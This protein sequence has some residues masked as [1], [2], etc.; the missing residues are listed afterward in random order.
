MA[1]V[2]LETSLEGL[3][4]FKKGKVRDTYDLGDKLLMISTDRIS[5]YDC[6]LPNGIPDKG[7]VLTACSLYWFDRTK[8]IIENHVITADVGEY[9]E[10]AMKYSNLLEGRSMLVK[11]TEPVL[12]E[13]VARG[14]LT[15]S[16]WR[17]YKE[18][19]SVCGIELPPGLTE[20]DKLPEPIF[21]PATKAESGHD[22]NVT[23]EQAVEIVGR[24][25]FDKLKNYTLRIYTQ[26]AR[27]AEKRG[28]IIADTKFEFGVTKEG[29][30]IF[31]D[32]VLTPDSS[33]FW[34]M[35]DYEPGKPQKS[36][37]KQYVR[38]YLDTLDWDKTPPAPELPEDVVE[39]TRKKYIEAYERLTGLEFK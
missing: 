6:I 7:R 1:D 24:E 25:Q 4:L 36:F 17:E 32:E 29:K 38:D 18:T 23:E 22:I 10:E 16:G 20:S 19:S 30:L 9:P 37:D 31:I 2:V 5:A 26:A 3:R 27:E 15:G 34:S 12:L 39:N 8:S 13:C 21:T 35:E 14:Y 33:R 11:K 28:M